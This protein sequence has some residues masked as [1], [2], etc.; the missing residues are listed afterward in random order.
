MKKSSEKVSVKPKAGRVMNPVTGKWMYLGCQ[1]AAKWLVKTG[2]IAKVSGTTVRAIADGRAEQLN[3]SPDT[4]KLVKSEF[5]ALCGITDKKTK[6]K[7]KKGD[8][9]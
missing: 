2:R 7:K 6:N 8:D 5:P 1:D 9:R 3:Y 4:V